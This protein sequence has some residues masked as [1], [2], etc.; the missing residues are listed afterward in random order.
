MSVLLENVFLAEDDLDDVDFFTEIV[1]EFVPPK[2]LQVAYDGFEF[3]EMLHSAPVKP[4]IIFLDLNM[5]R[6]TGLE[7]LQEI[8]S[9][10]YFDNIPVVMISTAIAGDGIDRSFEQGAHYYMVKPGSYAQF[11]Q[12]INKIFSTDFGAPQSRHEF[13]IRN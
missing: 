4:S 9:D 11:R 10:S 8:K 6:K 3:M 2:R 1:G 5:P 7:C 12:S 13:L